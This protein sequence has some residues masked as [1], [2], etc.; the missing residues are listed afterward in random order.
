MRSLLTFPLW[1]LLL[2]SLHH[3]RCV[4]LSPDTR[5]QISDDETSRSILLRDSCS[6]R[7]APSSAGL[8]DD[9]LGDRCRSVCGGHA[10][11]RLA[12]SEEERRARAVLTTGLQ[13][14]FV[15]HRSF[16]DGRF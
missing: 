7:V 9:R 16:E 6:S 15:S 11:E 13:S 2:L 4:R 8:G 3:V 10:V 14:N 1:A 5:V 12:E